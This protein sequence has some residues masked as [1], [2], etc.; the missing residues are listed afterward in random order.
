MAAFL[1]FGGA[2]TYNPKNT[3]TI[4]N[5]LINNITSVILDY[6]MLLNSL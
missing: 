6:T 1:K 2:C 5:K 3:T 4:G